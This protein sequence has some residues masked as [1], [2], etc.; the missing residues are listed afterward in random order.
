MRGHL[1]VVFLFIF[2]VYTYNDFNKWPYSYAIYTLRAVKNK[3][4]ITIP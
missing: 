3:K 1:T 2:S 4:N